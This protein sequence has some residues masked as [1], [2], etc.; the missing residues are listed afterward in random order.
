MHNSSTVSRNS[1][2]HGTQAKPKSSQPGINPSI[3]T[4]L[5]SSTVILRS[6]VPKYGNYQV[7]KKK[8]KEGAN[9]SEK[10]G[11]RAVEVN[12]SHLNKPTGRILA[13]MA[14]IVVGQKTHE[15]L[16]SRNDSDHG[17]NSCS[18]SHQAGLPAQ[19]SVSSKSTNSV[20]SVAAVPAV[21]SSDRLHRDSNSQ[22]GTQKSGKDKPVSVVDPMQAGSP[23]TQSTSASSTEEQTLGLDSYTTNNNIFLEQWTKSA[24]EA[25]CLKEE[26]KSLK[27]QLEVQLQ[28]NKELKRLLVASVGEDLCQRVEH[29]IR[30]KA[31]LSADLGDFAKKMTEDYEN[32][33]KVSIQAD[34]WRS[35][36]LASRL[37]TDELAKSKAFYGVQYQESQRVLQELLMERHELRT[38]LSESYRCLQQVRDAFDPLNTHKSSNLQSSN[39]IDLAKTIQN[40]AET[41]RFRLLPPGPVFNSTPF[42]L[43]TRVWT[44]NLTKGE[45]SAQELLSRKVDTSDLSSFSQPSSTMAP[46]SFKIDRYHPQM[47]FDNLTLNCCGECKGDIKV[48]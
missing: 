8:P 20:Q 7:G 11:V 38:N 39:V 31:Q 21:P 25:M 37:M 22:Q 33:D 41:I 45:S 42:N 6:A 4:P 30:D 26:N 1:A 14:P 32:L 44:D 36:Y 13:S 29:L 12:L 18:K 34:M 24:S 23:V 16:R 43:D 47:C 10:R 2:K 27:S 46:A 35:K 28:V 15:A 48:L 9:S 40:L 19:K 17:V 5:D 3:Q